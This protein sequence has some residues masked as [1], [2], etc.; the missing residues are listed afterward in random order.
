MNIFVI[1]HKDMR[2]ME[3]EVYGSM[4]NQTPGRVDTPGHSTR[5]KPTPK[6]RTS[7]SMD[8]TVKN[9]SYSKIWT[10]KEKPSVTTSNSGPTGTQWAERSKAAWCLWT[11]SG[12]SSPPTTSPRTSGPQM[13]SYSQPLTDGLNFKNLRNLSVLIDAPPLRGITLG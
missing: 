7:G 1:S 9:A 10:A 2:L 6:P 11:T 3:S 5:V 12:S 4:V 8:T 13:N